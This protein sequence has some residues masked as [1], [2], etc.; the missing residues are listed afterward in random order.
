MMNNKQLLQ[1]LEGLGKNSR[2]ARSSS[3]SLAAS[4]VMVTKDNRD[5]EWDT[6]CAKTL[7]NIIENS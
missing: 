2:I 5:R 7:R 4:E 1:I 3:K 6:R